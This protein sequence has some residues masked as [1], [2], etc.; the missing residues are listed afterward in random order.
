MV[1]VDVYVYICLYSNIMCF[2]AVATCAANVVVLLL[3]L[4]LWT[5]FACGGWTDCQC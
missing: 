5:L 1:F 2:T 4:L 3:L